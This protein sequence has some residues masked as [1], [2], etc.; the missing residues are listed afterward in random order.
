[1]LILKAV[2]GANG[3]IIYSAKLLFLCDH[4]VI[5]NTVLAPVS[6]EEEC[7]NAFVFP[8]C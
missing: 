4:S 5:H 6:S 1:M 3:I 2:D 7:M 8:D